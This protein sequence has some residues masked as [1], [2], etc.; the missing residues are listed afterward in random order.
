MKAWFI[1]GN[2]TLVTLLFIPVLSS[3]AD[4]FPPWKKEPAAFL[5][6]KLEAPLV[7]QIPKC[8][9]SVMCYEM[10]TP[11][12]NSAE[13]TAKLNNLP[14][15]GI[16]YLVSAKTIDGEVVQLTP[17]LSAWIKISPEGNISKIELSAARNVT[18]NVFN[19]VH[20]KY[21]EA[22]Y[23]ESDKKNVYSFTFEKRPERNRSYIYTYITE[24]WYGNKLQIKL[25]YLDDGVA[26]CDEILPD[27]EGNGSKDMF[28]MC[29]DGQKVNLSVESNAHVNLVKQKKQDA[30]RRALDNL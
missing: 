22:Q 14:D 13:N 11:T 2:L 23:V 9:A 25:H 26:H 18:D 19:L 6:L 12:K 1:S 30:E 8:P 3:A 29:E 21:G 17:K 28:W 4:T 15:I 7:G 5:G 27:D 20:K 10:S 16:P 24:H